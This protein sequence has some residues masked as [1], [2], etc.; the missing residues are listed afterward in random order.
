VE[1]D[2]KKSQKRRR[3]CVDWN[4][5]GCVQFW[6]EHGEGVDLARVATIAQRPPCIRDAG[7]ENDAA[8]AQDAC[9][10]LYADQT[11]GIIDCQVVALL[12]TV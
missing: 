4:Q 10:A 6:A 12:P 9:F 5:V 8:F 1:I 11:A 7:L 3:Q 2:T